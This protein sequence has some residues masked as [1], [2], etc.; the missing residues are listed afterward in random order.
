MA[1][2]EILRTIRNVG[3]LHRVSPSEYSKTGAQPLC[4]SCETCWVYFGAKRFGFSRAK[5]WQDLAR[6]RS[7]RCSMD[8]LR[9]QISQ[10]SPAPMYNDCGVIG[11]VFPGCRAWFCDFCDVFTPLSSRHVFLLPTLAILLLLVS[12]FWVVVL[13]CRQVRIWGFCCEFR[14]SGS[15]I[16]KRYEKISHDHVWCCQSW[17][18]C[19]K[20]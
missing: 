7:L 3:N 18:R 15:G 17:S 6:I 11:W 8:M 10:I 14:T 2:H 1:V 20:C 5:T 9:R 19:A 13:L 4:F 16:S 12:S